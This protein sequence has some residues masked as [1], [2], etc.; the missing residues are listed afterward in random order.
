MD[1]KDKRCRFEEEPISIIGDNLVGSVKNHSSMSAFIER[2]VASHT[3]DISAKTVDGRILRKLIRHLNRIDGINEEKPACTTEARWGDE[4]FDH[5]IGFSL[6]KNQ[7]GKVNEI[8]RDTGLDQSVIF[9]CCTYRYLFEI[10]NQPMH[11]FH[12]DWKAEQVKHRWANIESGLIAPQTRFHEILLRRFT[13][14]PQSTTRLI[15]HDKQRFKHFAD[16]YHT[17]FYGS[18]SYERI[19]EWYGEKTFNTVESIIEGETDHS[20]ESE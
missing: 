6:S 19:I 1:K 15:S 13:V 8:K 2:A 12:H 9:R 5:P 10:A 7:L 18:D 20:F 16:I 3:E 14:S 4:D 11:A 17:E